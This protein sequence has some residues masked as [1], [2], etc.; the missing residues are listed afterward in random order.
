[1]GGRLAQGK[2]PHCGAAVREDRATHCWNCGRRYLVKSTGFSESLVRILFGIG[3]VLCA[4]AMFFFGAGFFFW[5]RLGET[6][7]SAEPTKHIVVRPIVEQTVTPTLNESERE[8]INPIVDQVTEPTTIPISTPIPV[9]IP[10]S[11]PDPL[12]LF[13]DNFDQGL[14]IDWQEDYGEWLM[15]DEQ[16]SVINLVEIVP[17]TQEARVYLRDSNWHNYTID[18]DV[19]DIYHRVGTNDKNS[20]T[21]YIDMQD[22]DN[23]VW[24]RIASYKA[25][26]GIIK[27]G[28]STGIHFEKL[29]EV[30]NPTPIHIEVHG[31]TYEF[32]VGRNRICFFED[33]TFLSGKIGLGMYT[34]RNAVQWG[35][36][37]IPWIDN[38]K[39][40]RFP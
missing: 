2:C 38:F 4:G 32:L 12:A 36:K 35:E 11:T 24:F 8:E 1:M 31:K 3:F 30:K 13:E 22:V 17:D 7:Q 34:S 27:D 37:P 9:P 6:N 16:L 33:D 19:G 39:V 14:K 26:C 21:I 23:S 28:I 25:D 10:T 29:Q 15:V 40:A 18:M 5:S 20:M